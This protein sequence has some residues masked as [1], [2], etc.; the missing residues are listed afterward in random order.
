MQRESLREK[1]KPGLLV[2]HSL[3]IL[4]HTDI[5]SEQNNTSVSIWQIFSTT[6]TICSVEV[7]APNFNSGSPNALRLAVC[8]SAHER[9]VD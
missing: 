2:A 3:L 6:D 1:L 4:M 7:T 5:L 8:A 9:Y